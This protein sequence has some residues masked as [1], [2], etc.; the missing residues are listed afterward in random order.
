MR[1]ARS[2]WLTWPLKI[3]RTGLLFLVLIVQATYTAN[4]AAFLSAP[5]I[6]IHGPTT[7][8]GLA[9][10]VVCVLHPDFSSPAFQY[11]G[12]VVMASLDELPQLASGTIDIDGRKDWVRDQL[13]T[14][15]CD[16]WMHDVAVL[17]GEY[18]ASCAN[19]ELASWI[20]VAPI[21]Y[22]M[23]GFNR[24]LV[25]NLSA[26]IASFS[27]MP[28]FASLQRSHFGT[29]L[30][31]G[32][33]SGGSDQPITVDM[34]AGMYI[35]YAALAGVAVRNTPQRGLAPQRAPHDGPAACILTVLAQ[36]VPH[37]R[38]SSRWQ[39]GSRQ[40]SPRRPWRPTSTTPPPRVRCCA[41]C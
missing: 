12:S 23:G 2:E 33:E 21:I 25:A 6:E 10:S 14:G 5:S 19:R 15:G 3:L 27:Q 4:L 20:N 13:D 35:I 1:A 22:A 39:I 16:I 30:T 8:D 41:P 36:T 28:E 29:G 17:Q 18:L 40:P 37:F 24:S 34:M 26:G 9:E 31:C 11:G 7:M 38:C 32:A